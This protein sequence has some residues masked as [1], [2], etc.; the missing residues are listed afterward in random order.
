MHLVV[1]EKNISNI[2]LYT[3]ANNLESKLELI[4]MMI[5]SK[6]FR[7]YDNEYK[8]VIN[9]IKSFKFNII[10][11]LKKKK[12]IEYILVKYFLKLYEFLMIRKEVKIEYGKAETKVS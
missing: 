4:K 1:E 3:K 12:K 6:A 11:Q 2:L 7:Q 5:K 9:E 10:F 8:K